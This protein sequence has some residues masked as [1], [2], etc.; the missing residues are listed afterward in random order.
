MIGKNIASLRKKHR[1]TQIEFA[2]RIHVTQGAVSQWE[3]GRT[4]P[5]TQQLIQIANLFNVD[6]NALTDGDPNTV[7]VSVGHSGPIVSGRDMQSAITYP[8]AKA[9]GRSVSIDYGHGESAVQLYNAAGDS[10]ESL[11]ERLR[12][13]SPARLQQALDYITFLEQQDD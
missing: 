2:E 12:S 4:N 10:G 5:D 6:L 3:T 7:T 1:L 9:V 11:I 8:G 13:L